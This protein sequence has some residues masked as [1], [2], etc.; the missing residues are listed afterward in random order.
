[1]AFDLL[2]NVDIGDVRTRYERQGEQRVPLYA[3]RERLDLEPGVQASSNSTLQVRRY[4]GV[5][6][7]PDDGDVYYVAVSH[8][9]APW[10]DAGDQ[11]YAIAVELLEEERLDL[12]LYAAVQQ[13]VQVRAR[14][15][16]RR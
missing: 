7:D 4:R 13:Q 10:A 5:Q 2:R 1:M 16:V 12:D 8:R 6:L 3:G 15:R 11:R 9:S 14:A